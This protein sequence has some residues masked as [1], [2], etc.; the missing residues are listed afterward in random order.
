METKY[1]VGYDNLT[2]T[3]FITSKK[4]YD[5]Y[6]WDARK[7]RRFTGVS[8][9]DMIEIFE[10]NYKDCTYEVVTQGMC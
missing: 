9:T 4:N 7:F 1:I 8:L 5:S 6:I 10:H 3:G 2:H